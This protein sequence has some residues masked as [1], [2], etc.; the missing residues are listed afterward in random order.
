M[1]SHATMKTTRNATQNAPRRHWRVFL[2]TGPK[3]TLKRKPIS[4]CA[5]TKQPQQQQ[6]GTSER[7][8]GV[9]GEIRSG[10]LRTDHLSPRLSY[11]YVDRTLTFSANANVTLLP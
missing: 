1:S 9:R 8:L 7:R 10:R 3:M 5:A 6:S 4:T 2:G 11:N